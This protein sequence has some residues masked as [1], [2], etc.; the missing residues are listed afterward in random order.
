MDNKII[1]TKTAKGLREAT[2]KTRALS[3]RLR[4]VLKEVDGK[5]SVEEMLG[6]FEEVQE[7][8]LWNE[9]NTLA[10]ENYI[11]E[12]VQTERIIEPSEDLDFSGLLPPSAEAEAMPGNKGL[13][14]ALRKTKETPA[15]A[16]VKAKFVVQAKRKADEQTRQVAE[17]QARREAEEKA[18]QEAATKAKREAEAREREKAEVQARREAEANLL[19]EIEEHA[20]RDVEAKAKP[21][22]DG[23]A[24][25]EG[26]DQGRKAAEAKASREAE[27]QAKRDTE[28]RAQREADEKVRRE[29]EERSRREVEEKARREAAKVARRKAEELERREMEDKTRREAEEKAKREAEEVARREAEESAKREAEEKA[30]QEADEARRK[31]EEQEKRE[32][33]ERARREAEEKA[34]REAEEK[35]KRDTEERARREADEQVRHEA[36]ERLRRE[37]EEKAQR[38]AEEL[39]RR[40][41]E[42]EARHKV[43]EQAK[44]EAEEQARRESEETVR[45]D[46]EEK[47]RQ[48][49]EERGRHEAEERSRREAE[50]IARRDAEELAR[51]EAEEQARREA[52]QRANHEA[53]ESAR[54]A[55]EE[56]ARREAEDSARH[57]ADE[58]AKT[59]AAEAARREAEEKAVR[60]A[61][62]LAK[63]KALALV[64]RKAKALA[65]QQAEEK[66]SNNTAG[67]AAAK[68][69]RFVDT[70]Q[71]NLGKAIVL[72]LFVLITLGLGL[73][74]VV[75][76]DGQM[77][78]LEKAASDQFQ[79]PVNIETMHLALFPQPN[80]IIEGVSI[81]SKG[82]IMVG[83]I[84]AV[85][86]LG[87]V[88]SEK[89][90]F[91]SVELYAPI[92]NDDGLRWLMFGK[93]RSDAFRVER[94]SAVSAKLNSKSISP[95]TFD[96]KAEVGDDGNWQ[97]IVIFTSDNNGVI[98]LQPKG[99]RVQVEINADRF[100]VPFGSALTLGSF[101]AIGTAGRNDLNVTEF[102]GRLYGGFVSGTA[103]LKWATNWSL[104][105][106]LSARRIASLQ[107]VPGL[108]E[109]G[110]IGGTGIYSMRG[111]DA[112]NLFAAPHVEGSFVVHDGVL[113]GVNLANLLKN[114]GSGGK[115]SF[116]EL[117]GSFVHNSNRTQLKQMR[118]TAGIVSASGSAEADANA[119]IRGR[120]GADLKYSTGQAHANVAVSGSLKQPRFSR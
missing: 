95:L 117:V 51:R 64:K 37:A 93:A 42:E 22:A 74:H 17:A 7:A 46:A 30:R 5:S 33:E 13:S 87:S 60:K 76:F 23:K 78:K 86:E 113:L 2:G 104:D 48:E 62:A 9:L 18:K 69:E 34:R 38:E 56:L 66:V 88:F 44:W 54:R 10:E 25:L 27:E 14:D 105:G 70:K 19:R 8:E 29:A 52:E 89:Q 112:A 91:K 107:A 3:R 108:L 80:W 97:K 41:A 36:E 90:V 24:K 49:A 71:L 32:A 43:E 26:Q 58:K 82:Q 45:R 39:A 109:S 118:L 68:S 102:T 115:T 101:N 63:K 110:E 31:V 16:A 55:S 21:A 119:N 85:I 12:F 114:G 79:Q 20:K 99:N 28:A 98:E 116:S 81:G 59:E 75:S 73:V 40:E 1:F 15:E 77:A 100:A 57:E 4:V 61:E 53:E 35:A 11:R 47:T 106:D 111:A 83:K 94:F 120:F 84:K 6:R 50:E 103:R 92:L 96:L 65:R 72:G 67:K